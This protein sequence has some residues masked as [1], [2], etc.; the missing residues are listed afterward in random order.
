MTKE[1]I[2]ETILSLSKLLSIYDADESLETKRGFFIQSVVNLLKLKTTELKA[3]VESLQSQ[4]K[5]ESAT[6]SFL[7]NEL[8]E[9]RR[10][11]L[12]DARIITEL[13]SQLA[14]AEADKQELL[15]LA[16]NVRYYQNNK[17]TASQLYKQA[18][19]L[20]NKHGNNK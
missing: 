18:N 1:E 14:K 16:I 6:V 9:Y 13:Q 20:I 19:Q 8:G 12:E 4:L 17:I 15:E 2:E 5:E 10:L 7:N 11:N 3:E